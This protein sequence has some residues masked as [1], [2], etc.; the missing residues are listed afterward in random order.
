VNMAATA[1]NIAGS[2]SKKA[3]IYQ[4]KAIDSPVF[5][6]RGQSDIR[7]VPPLGNKVM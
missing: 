5:N 2:R 1:A 4:A 6:T 7:T 3:H